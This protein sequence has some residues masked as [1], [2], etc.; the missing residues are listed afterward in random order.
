MSGQRIT[1]Q[2]TAAILV[3][4][5]LG[6]ISFSATFHSRNERFEKSLLLGRVEAQVDMNKYFDSIDTDTHSHA[7]R[8]IDQSSRRYIDNKRKAMHYEPGTFTTIDSNGDA[9]DL[10]KVWTAAAAANDMDVYYGG[11][12]PSP[13]PPDAS[14]S[15]VIIEP[16]TPEHAAFDTSKASKL[17][18]A[19]RAD[20]SLEKRLDDVHAEW[21]Q[22]HQAPPTSEAERRTYKAMVMA[23]VAN[24]R[25]PAAT[26][27]AAGLHAAA[28]PAKTTSQD[29]AEMQ[30]A[31]QA[32]YRVLEARRRAA[33]EADLAGAK[34]VQNAAAA[35]Y[36]A[37]RAAAAAASAAASAAA[38]GQG[39]AAGEGWDGADYAAVMAA[40]GLDGGAAVTVP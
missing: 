30:R 39:A 32:R 19:M 24:N 4:S 36:R 16:K 25:P 40:D 23:A 8:D 22:H 27:P 35:A 3:I 33:Q 1:L 20:P 17:Q 38:G 26:A 6:V 21:F 9:R 18:A 34:A 11:E 14:K 37:K 12:A 31:E 28:P 29:A 13:V 7:W 10:K 2:Y 15:S 5:M